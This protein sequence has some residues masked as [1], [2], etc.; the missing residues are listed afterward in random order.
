MDMKKLLLIPICLLLL[1]CT[2]QKES[3][4]DER[5]KYYQEYLA[6]ELS[7]TDYKDLC[8]EEIEVQHMERFYFKGIKQINRDKW[9]GRFGLLKK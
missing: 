2:A 1:S 4:Q 3:F 5:P 7:Y 6:G 8:V 9:L